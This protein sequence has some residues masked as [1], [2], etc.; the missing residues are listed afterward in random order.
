[1]N[2]AVFQLSELQVQGLEFQKLTQEQQNLKTKLDELETA[3]TQ[4]ED[5]VRT[6]NNQHARRQPGSAL[7]PSLSPQVAR[8]DGALGLMEAQHL[9]WLQQQEQAEE[10]FRE[11][12]ELLQARLAEEQRRSR[13]LEEALRLQAQQ[14]SSQIGLKQVIAQVALTPGIGLEGHGLNGAP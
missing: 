1:M 12:V 7:M 13:Q 4:A 5:Q 6:T 11:Q 3:R 2:N 9:R 14:S 8:A 10:G